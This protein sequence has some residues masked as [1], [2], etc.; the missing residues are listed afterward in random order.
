MFF[1]S[2]AD[3]SPVCFSIGTLDVYWYG[4]AYVIGIF[5]SLQYARHLA[6]RF[7]THV[8]PKDVD[9]FLPFLC[10]GILLGGRLGH[11]FFY[12]ASYYLAHPLEILNTRQGGMAFH[13][14]L[15]GVGIAL[16][17]FCKRRKIPLLRFLDVLA[18]ATP[19]GLGL[20][21]CANF[22]NNELYGKPTA[23]PFGVH[24]R[25]AELPRHPTQLYEAFLEGVLLWLLLR[26]C[27]KL[28]F[29]QKNPGSVSAVFLIG[30]AIFRI[31]VDCFKA[32]DA[33]YDP[34]V[35]QTL[36]LGMLCVGMVWLYQLKQRSKNN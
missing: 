21:R 20:G 15:I 11:V 30:Y 35:G 36:S 5:L 26:Q 29:F 14:G 34:L 27:W 25:H 3:W 13:G 28:P 2:V 33:N 10:L 17:C 19:I 4:L 22:I 12:E 8:T 6:K 9:A 23:L 32:A 18:A 24:F 31:I 1:F 7:C 16:Y